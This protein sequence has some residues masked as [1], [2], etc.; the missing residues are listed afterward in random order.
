MVCRR[1][2]KVVGVQCQVCDRTSSSTVQE[3]HTAVYRGSSTGRFLST[4][5][6]LCLSD[7]STDQLI[8]ADCCLVRPYQ[9]CILPRTDD[10]HQHLQR[11]WRW[12]CA[13]C[14][15]YQFLACGPAARDVSLQQ[16]KGKQHLSHSLWTKLAA[17]FVF[18]HALKY[19]VKIRNLK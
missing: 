11:Q 17:I 4:S 15:T 7:C 2:T 1:R 9:H 3:S 8:D 16:Q 18:Y 5:P 13:S 6:S 10:W 12:S 19:V 14:R